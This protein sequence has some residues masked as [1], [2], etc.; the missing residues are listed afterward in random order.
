MATRETHAALSRESMVY[1][2]TNR[3]TQKVTWESDVVIVPKIPGNAGGG[4]DD[5]QEGLVQGKHLLYAGIGIKMATELG[6]IEEMS[7]QNPRMVFTSLYHLINEELLRDCHREIDGKKA[8][9]VDNV[10]KNEYESN[11]EENLKDLE[12]RLKRKSYKP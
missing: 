12:E 2:A 7:A 5:T 1:N 3:G 4:K 6:R 10:T 9:G 8:T 11:L